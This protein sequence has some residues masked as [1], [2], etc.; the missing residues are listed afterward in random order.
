MTDD[1]APTPTPA[2]PQDWGFPKADWKVRRRLLITSVAFCGVAL[3]FVLW[4]GGDGPLM[5]NALYVFAFAAVTLIGQY[6]FGATW[7]D[8]NFRKAVATMRGTV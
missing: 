4:K 7:D 6:V 1:S 2:P 8:H 5:Q 3:A